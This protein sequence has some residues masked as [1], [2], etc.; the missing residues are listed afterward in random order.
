MHDYVFDEILRSIQLPLGV[1]LSDGCTYRITPDDFNQIQTKHLSEL[2]YFEKF[3]VLTNGHGIVVG[4]VLFY[5]NADLQVTI[6]E[7]Y[8]G[9]H[10]MSA[11]H[12]NGVLLSE[13][14]SNQC[15]T[16]EEDRILSFDDFLKKHYMASLIG[17]KITN[18]AKI[19][20]YMNMFMPCD[21][22]RGF[23]QL[24]REEF[25]SKFS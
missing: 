15:I 12:K 7:E 17:L 6:F 8:R 4:G 9:M 16:I 14:Y 5:G 1:L 21:K 20:R 19:H 24:S 3:L 25:I 2:A 22:L 18:L 11:I 13:C 23:Q 10:F